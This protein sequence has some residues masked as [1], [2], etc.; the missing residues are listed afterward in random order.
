[1][2]IRL[3]IAGEEEPI[4]REQQ[5]HLRV[6]PEEYDLMYSIQKQYSLGYKTSASI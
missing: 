5:I 3:L 1:M 4:M 6:S 2:G